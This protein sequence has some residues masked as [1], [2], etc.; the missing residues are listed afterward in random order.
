MAKGHLLA[1]ACVLG[2]ILGHT[3]AAQE[4]T[5]QSQ[6]SRAQPVM[7]EEVIVTATRRTE[8]LQEVPMSIS[9]FTE[10]FF[11]DTGV[12]QLAELDQYTPNLNITASTDSRSTSIRIRGIGSVGTNSGID[13]SV[14]LFIDGVYQGRS[15]MSI[16]DL[17]DIQRVEVLRGP[18]GT[19]YGKNTSAGAISIVTNK[20]T[21]DYESFLEVG[22][23]SDEKLELRGMVNLP[24]GDSGNALRLTG[25]TIDGDHLYDNTHTGKGVND[26]SK[27]GARGHLLF[28]LG[29]HGD[30]D[31]GDLL[32]TADYT[33]E[34]TD[35]CAFSVIE[36]DGL[37]LLNS[38]ST[39]TPSAEWQAR[40]GNN[41]LGQPILAYT[42]FEDS[43]GMSPPAANPFGDDRWQDV[44]P[45][46]KV[47]IGGISADWS[48]EFASEDA[49]TLIAAY[50]NYT[51]DSAFD[52]DFTAYPAVVATT[53]V[54]LDQ[55]SAEFRIT[56]PGAET[57]DYQAGLYAYYSEFDSMGEFAQTAELVR[58]IRIVGDLTL[59]ALFPD[60]TL[61][62]DDN[63]YTTTSYAAFGQASWNIS[64][65]FVATLGLRYTYE[66]KEREGSQV[67]T[68]TSV[69]DLP[70]VAGPDTFY[71]S[72][73]S[74]S[75][76]SPSFNLRYFVNPDVM[77]YG[78]V[79][80]GFKSGGFNQRREVQGSEGEFDEEIA[81]NY[82]LGWKTTWLN[83]QVVFNGTFFF[84]DYEDFQSQTFDGTTL[85]VTNAG[86]LESYGAEI[87][88][89]YVPNSSFTLGTAIGFN[90]AE[91]ESFDNGQCTV[92]AAFTQ[93]YIDQ[94]A[95]TGAPAT[96]GVC[97]EDLA[98]EPLANAPEWTI[99]SF[100][101]YDQPL[102]DD[103]AALVRLE[104]NYIDGHFLEEDLD[105]HLKNDSVN[106]VNLRLGLHN[107]ERTWE[108]TL[109]A[110]NILDE[111][112][113]VYGLDI[114]TLGGYAGFVA[115]EATFGVTLL[116]YQ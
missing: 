91:Y 114:P 89:M 94:G 47:E 23:D 76:I 62:I 70:P 19:L 6:A 111:E 15:G 72:K 68:P 7:L 39:N 56:S 116:L 3:A 42:A 67:T 22:Y 96:L 26:A 27:W 88:A 64:D 58:N 1:A 108:A 101:Q 115:P 45:S 65:E 16:T 109:W 59:A 98:G 74:D 29:K 11:L 44:S 25:F 21:V 77:L 8:N 57:I 50:R 28:P 63:L 90:K 83:R 37:S 2:P 103:L 86:N 66:K 35:C 10:S 5:T 24:L 106:L 105:P 17:V 18:Q 33:K 9:A 48:G 41:A 87:E 82:E 99:S 13:P 61:N 53:D 36:Y 51:S 85:R 31:F 40:L 80:R 107:Q 71:D 14:G 69:L 20:P 113:Y 55:Y 102:G 112:Y 97:T 52:G 81:T 79:S 46:N 93:Y 100:V 4:P 73:R 84:V 32:I 49:F 110:R 75:D 12:D 38:P 92:E 104:H 30:T 60:G 43:A 95:Q 34:D 78:L 54:E